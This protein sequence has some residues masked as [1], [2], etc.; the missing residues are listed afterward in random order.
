MNKNSGPKKIIY[1]IFEFMDRQPQIVSLILAAGNAS[2]MGIP[3]QLL[4]AENTTLL[5]KCIKTSLASSCEKTYVVL[6]AN[7]ELISN[8]LSN[9]KI[10]IILNTDWQEGIASSIRTGVQTILEEDNTVD[11]VLILLADQVMVEAVLLNTLIDTYQSLNHKIVA[12]K[13][14]ET[15]GSPALFDKSVISDLLKLE[16]NAGAKKVMEKHKED[17]TLIDF[18]GGTIDVDTLDDYKAYLHFLNQNRSKK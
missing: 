5:E 13:Y 2:R 3:K 7:A 8:Q 11:G 12:C 14:A 1:C 10:N 4:T 9:F 18:P 15:I 17:L 16:G 6:G